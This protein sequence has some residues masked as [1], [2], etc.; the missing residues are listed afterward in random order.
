MI[1]LHNGAEQLPWNDTLAKKGWGYPLQGALEMQP[2]APKSTIGRESGIKVVPGIDAA[3]PKRTER[4]R[5]R[6]SP[7][8]VA[9]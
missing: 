4:Q 1:L 9:P 3:R 5:I 7:A 8:T 6:I 2:A